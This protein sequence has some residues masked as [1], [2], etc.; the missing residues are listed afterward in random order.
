MYTNLKVLKDCVLMGKCVSKNHHLHIRELA[1]SSAYI[2][3]SDDFEYFHHDE[4][5]LDL[6]MGIWCIL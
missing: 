2:A 5:R 4:V 3:I 1:D 6:F